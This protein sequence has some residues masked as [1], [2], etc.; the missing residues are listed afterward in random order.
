M[1]ILLLHGWNH[2]NYTSLTNELDA[3]HNRLKF[4]GELSKENEVYKL[5]FPGFCGEKEPK[6]KYWE[7]DDYAKYVDEFVKNNKLK[8]DYI[9]GYS[10]GGAVALKYNELFNKNQKL[11][12]ISPA[13]VRNQNNS[14]KMIKTPKI[15]DPIRKVIR[16]FY[17]IRIKKNVYMVNGTKFLR[18]SYQHIVRVDLI[19]ILNNINYKCISIIY[20]D[21]DSMVNPS[22]VYN[23]VN[24]NYKKNIH[25]IKNGGHDIANTHTMELIEIINEIIKK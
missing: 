17:L 23:S 12:L 20:G 16:D 2:K 11:I 19:P 13:I 8:I 21:K 1:K 18:E 9:I 25:F 10:F 3:W 15:F 6:S 14:K 5:N 24:N 4:V 7:L 22:L